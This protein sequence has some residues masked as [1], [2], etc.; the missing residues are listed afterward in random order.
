[1]DILKE[2]IAHKQ[3]EVGELKQIKP[4]KLL[5][6][7]AYFNTACVSLTEYLNRTD[8]NGIIAEF[9]R[10][11][12]S[13]GKIN[14]YASVQK[15]SVGYMQS[16]ASALSILTD[17]KY[18][19][20]SESD[21]ITARKFNYCPILRKDFI[22]DEYQVYE[23]KAMGADVL[24]LIAAGLE[25]VKLKSLAALANKLGLEV[26]LEIRTK[27]ELDSAFN[28]HITAVGVNN[29]NLHTFKVDVEQSFTLSNLIPANVV[30]I[31]ESGISKTE[32]INDLKAA[33]YKGFLI[34][35]T[36]MK[37]SNP[38]NTCQNLIKELNTSKEYAL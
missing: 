21:L 22:I 3:T 23:T 5:E 17:K 29:R 35:E 26:L 16:G 31:S 1:M 37:T 9:K 36:F 30:K 4:I 33:G 20:G 24:L 32:T 19:G 15:T 10:Q 27:E 28:E 14:P 2:I 12:P 18:F 6:R 34:G 38:A 25:P 7:S 13:L 8:L 11:S